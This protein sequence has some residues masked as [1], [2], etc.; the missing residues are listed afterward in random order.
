M[1][2]SKRLRYEIIR[3]D[4]GTCR[5]CGQ[6]APDVPLTV[7]HVIPTTLGGTDE[8]SNLVA[9]CRDCNSG[10]TSSAADAPFVANVAEDALLWRQ[11]TEL[12]A[13]QLR[14]DRGAEIEFGDHLITTWDAQCP[15][16]NVPSD[17]RTSAH[18]MYAA[19][20]SKD[21]ITYAINVT[22][23]SR[24]V[25]YHWSYFCGVVW[26][27]IRERDALAQQMMRDAKD[28]T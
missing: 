24:G 7:D 8:P 10:K 9:A 14:A 25:T 18:G 23:G 11:L 19:G 1:A 3:R 20:A 4:N 17:W 28:Y 15:R 6:H 2:V 5:Y 27:H 22:A 21:D 26:R 16:W 13:A 12:A